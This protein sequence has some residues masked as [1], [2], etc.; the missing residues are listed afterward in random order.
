MGYRCN[1]MTEEMYCGI[2]EWFLDKYQGKGYVINKC[3][4]ISSTCERKGHYDIL[5]DLQELVI[6]DPILGVFLWEDSRITCFKV[7]SNRYEI[8]KPEVSERSGTVAV[9]LDGLY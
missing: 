9:E 1:M 7:Y 3:G 5:K 6:E 8:E 2:P 4:P